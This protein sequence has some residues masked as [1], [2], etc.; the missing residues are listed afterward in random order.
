MPEFPEKKSESISTAQSFIL[1][2]GLPVVVHISTFALVKAGWERMG[3][4][5]KKDGQVLKYDGVY[6]M[7]DGKQVEFMED[8]KKQKK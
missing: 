7:L 4:T 6:W 8:L 5:Y 1:G 3:T 2:D